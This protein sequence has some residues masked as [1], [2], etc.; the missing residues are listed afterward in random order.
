MDNKPEYQNVTVSDKMEEALQTVFKLS[1]GAL[2]L[3]I[4]FKSGLVSD[5]TTHLWTLATSWIFLSLVV[6]SF[7][8]NK[9]IDLRV[10]MSVQSYLKDNPA[11][12]ERLNGLSSL[13]DYPSS[14]KKPVVAKLFCIL[15]L[16][17][18]FMFGVLFL[19]AFALTNLNN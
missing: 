12:I 1:T 5:A 15:T 13:H 9:L 14:L 4:T 16:F 8:A 3:S 11:D 19:L 6:F 2:A 10:K 18:S 17:I 7:V